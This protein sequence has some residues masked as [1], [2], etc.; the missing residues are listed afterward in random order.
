[1]M[2]GYCRNMWEPVYRIKVWYKSVHSVGYFYVLHAV[3]IHCA[4]GCVCNLFPAVLFRERVFVSEV[5]NN[6]N[7]GRSMSCR[8]DLYIRA[9]HSRYVHKQSL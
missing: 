8:T 9:I 1:M 2:A 7:I 6:V 4:L 3:V 5:K